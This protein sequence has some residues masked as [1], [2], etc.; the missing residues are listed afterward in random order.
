[1][2]IS[3]AKGLMKVIDFNHGFMLNKIIHRNDDKADHYKKI[4]LNPNNN[5]KN[6]GKNDR[7]K[8]FKDSLNNHCLT[9]TREDHREP[10][11]IDDSILNQN[12]DHMNMNDASGIK[13]NP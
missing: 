2:A 9:D 5:F 10:A 4:D 11:S 6:I 12:F 1:M 13:F 8:T 7:I 3:T